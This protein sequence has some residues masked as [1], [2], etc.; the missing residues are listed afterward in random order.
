[1]NKY[2]VFG[3]GING[4]GVIKF[5]RNQIIGVVDN[6]PKK[7]GSVFCGYKVISFNDDKDKEI[8]K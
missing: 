6:N 3:A 8:K 5:F 7:W 4:Y 2:Y 1:M